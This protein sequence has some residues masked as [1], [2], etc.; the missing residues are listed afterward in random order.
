MKKAAVA[1]G[2]ALASIAAAP[3][4]ADWSGKGRI[5]GVL[6]RG[7]SDTATANL[8]FD[9]TKHLDR[10]DNKLGGSMLRTLNAG[11]V[12]ADRWEARVGS[13]YRPT[14]RAFFFMA[15]RYEQDEFTDYAY[16]ATATLGVGYHFVATE[17]TKLDARLGAGTRRAELRITDE[18]ETDP[19]ARLGVEFTH[20]L[21]G[22]TSMFERLLVESGKSNT[23]VQN[24]IG[25]EVKMTQRFSL[26]LSYEVRRNSDVLPG[27]RN[28]DQVFSVG[29]VAALE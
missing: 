10:W 23:F 2:I 4:C 16:Q 15:G 14:E 5:G 6:V 18:I 12:S 13:D 25:L 21:T 11:I 17:T 27:T 19:I 3:A 1:A 22:N 28:S 8:D 20:Q 26:G 29:L 7:N 24:A 9:V